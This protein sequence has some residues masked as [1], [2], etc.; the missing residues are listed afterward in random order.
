MS[1]ISASRRSPRSGE[2]ENNQKEKVVTFVS[3]FSL[4]SIISFQLAG[5]VLVGY[6]LGR[7]LDGLLGTA[8]WLMVV[9]ILLGV[10]AG[11]SGTI[12]VVGRFF[13]QR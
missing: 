11:V 10:A 6:F 9:G 4:A 2:P 12:R 1:R 7:Y 13:E 8:P 3:A 5:A